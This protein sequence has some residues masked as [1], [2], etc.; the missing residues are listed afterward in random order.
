MH[1]HDRKWVDEQLTRLPPDLR[2]A[3]LE[4]YQRVYAQT[5]EQNGMTEARREANTRLRHY[6]ARIRKNDGN[7]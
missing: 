3:A 1:P 2:K 4:K 7:Y 6:I 5:L